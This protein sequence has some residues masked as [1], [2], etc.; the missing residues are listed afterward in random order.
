MQTNSSASGS[1]SARSRSA[2]KKRA[3]KPADPGFIEVRG[4]CEHNLKNVD[5]DIPR[6]KLVAFTGRSGSG[7]TTLA[8]DT[9]YA[10]G[11]RKYMES[12]SAD[13]RRALSQIDRPAVGSISGLSP[14]IAIEQMKSLG[15][16]PRSTLATLTEIADYSRLVWSVA[17][18]QRCPR[19]GGRISRRSLD[20]C[21]D[22]VLALPPD[23]RAYVLAP[24]ISGKPS[25]LKEELKSLR[26]QAW[27]RA[28]VAGK[29]LELDDPAAEKRIFSSL[30][31]SKTH[32]LEL[33]VDRFT[34]ASASRH[35]VADSLEL[36]FREGAG[37][38]TDTSSF[39][40]AS[41]AAGTGS[42]SSFA[43]GSSASG[44]EK[45]SSLR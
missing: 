8:F 26:Q 45:S 20:E 25:A 4:A 3:A 39:G 36:A 27:Q 21:V 29:V 41:W 5:V 18:E 9:I 23:A 2:S 31:A 34:S 37:S 28:G 7:K 40:A 11:Y 33:V 10:E 22:A 43:S 15:S 44:S 32:S 30:P 1:G 42:A 16:N 17:G 38:A 13:A 6:G 24:R 12:L 14:V 19:D 35:K